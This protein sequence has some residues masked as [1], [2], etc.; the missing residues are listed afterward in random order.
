MDAH[1]PEKLR[2]AVRA[3]AT[4]LGLRLTASKGSSSDVDGESRPAL[5]KTSGYV[6]INEKLGKEWEW[7]QHSGDPNT[8]KKLADG[9]ET[10]FKGSTREMPLKKSRSKPAR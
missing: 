6:R 4:Q 5:E 2:K 10:Y 7:E 1:E 8:I 9:L 3:V